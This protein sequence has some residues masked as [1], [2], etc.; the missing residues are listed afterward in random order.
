MT[1]ITA[2][3]STGQFLPD[4][5]DAA[6]KAAVPPAAEDPAIES[7]RRTKDALDLLA[8]SMIDMAEQRKAIAKEKL[9][10]AK[11][12]LLLLERFGFPPEVVARRAAQLG[13]KVGAAAAEFAAASSASAGAASAT[14]SSGTAAADTAATDAAAPMEETALPAAYR[15]A[16]DDGRQARARTDADRR[17]ANDFRTT[18]ERIRALI[19]RAMR[20]LRADRAPEALGA[21][22]TALSALD[23]NA[24][25]ISLTV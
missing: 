7:L 21:I 2:M 13:L 18:L 11:A 12:E 16:L 25:P 6:K 4:T 8:R 22:D 3:A 20:E 1:S 17:T 5:S 14:P 24:P 23:A 19:E 9:E 15:E 10:E